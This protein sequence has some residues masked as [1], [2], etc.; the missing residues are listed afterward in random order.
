M[1]VLTKLEMAKVM[2]KE[3]NH[4]KNSWMIRPCEIYYDEYKECKYWKSR[5]HQYF[6]HGHKIDCSS[7]QKDYHYC[8][9]WQENQS[10]EA[11]EALITSEKEHR[12]NRLKGHIGNKVWERRDKPPEDWNSP[13]PEWMEEKFKDSYLEKMK[14]K[15]VQ[16]KIE[17]INKYCVI[18]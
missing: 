12:I 1:N 15:E 3:E 6:I 11:Y 5:F 2:A 10:E 16:K 14:N 18:M 4:F 13:L 8:K 17:S 7:W 9:M